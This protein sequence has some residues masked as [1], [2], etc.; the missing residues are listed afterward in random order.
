MS[1]QDVCQTGKPIQDV[2]KSKSLRATRHEGHYHSL[3]E[4]TFVTT[5]QTT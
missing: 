3:M 1:K 5:I 4:K 2:L